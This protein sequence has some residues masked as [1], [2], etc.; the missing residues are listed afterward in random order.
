MGLLHLSTTTPNKLLNFLKLS[1][2]FCKTLVMASIS[3][4]PWRLKKGMYLKCFALSL[5][6]IKHSILDDS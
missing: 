2:L 3:H 5:T 6:K 1:L 4:W